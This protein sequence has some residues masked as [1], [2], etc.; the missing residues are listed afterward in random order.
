MQARHLLV[1]LLRQQVD[2]ILVG[3][4]LLP[5]FQKVQLRQDL[6][7]E[8]A[9]HHEG[10]V[11]RGAAKVEE[12]AGG[13]HDHAVPIREQEAVNLR[14]D[15]LDLD[16]FELL[17]ACHVNLI[18]KVADVTNDGVVLHLLHVLDC[19]DVL[20]ACGGGEDVDLPNHTLH[21]NH[22]EAL[23]A[24]LEGADRV[25]LGDEDPGAGAAHGEGAALAHVAVAAHKG[26]L[27]ANHDVGGAHDAVG[28]GVAAAVDVVELGLR[29]TVVH[30]D[31]REE[32][33]TLGGHFLQ[34]VHTSGRLLAHA[35]ALGGHPGVLCLVGLDGILQQ[36]QDALELWVVSACGVGQAA[37][38]RKPFLK[39]LALVDQERGITAIIHKLVATIG[40]RHGHHLLGAPPVLLQGLALPSKDGGRACLCNGGRCLIL[41]AEDVAGAPADRGTQR[42]QGLDQHAGLDGHV[43][44]A[45]DVQTLEGLLGAELGAGGHQPWHLVLCKLQLLPAKLGQTHVLDLGLRHA[46]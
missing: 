1:Q 22:L 23:H 43:Q 45:V 3:L 4:G 24:G 19:D 40:A 15:V 29:H 2:L 6:V 36:R 25:D 30:V 26:A 42:V 41:R 33:L 17:E 9:G 34:P 27:A 7:G 14:L 21:G 28:Q 31:G 20:V 32:E 10:R 11:A 13:Q 37:I 39:L 18:V 5:V 8:G 12:P 44:G 38:L 35:H 16:A 46:V